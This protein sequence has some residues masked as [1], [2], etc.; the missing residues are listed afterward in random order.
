MIA[1]TNSWRTWAVRGGACAVAA[2]L[3]MAAIPKAYAEDSPDLGDRAEVE[4]KKAEREALE[5]QR[6]SMKIEESD[7]QRESR[8][9]Q[10]AKDKRTK[11]AQ[12]KANQAV[13]AANKRQN[14]KGMALM[15]SAWMTDPLQPEYPRFTAEFAKALQKPEL[16]FRAWS[17]VKT[18]CKLN[19]ASLGPDSP[20]R[21]KYQDML[22]MAEP[23]L[24]FLRTK[25]STGVLQVQVDP[26]SCEI[27]VE[28]AYVG[29]GKGEMELMTGERKVETHCVGYKDMMQF[30]V[31]RQGDPSNA[32]IKCDPIP[33]FG[34]LVLKIDQ[35]EGVT[36]YLDDVPT[37]QRMGDK[38][39]KEGTI[40]GEGTKEKP[41]VL[42]ARRWVLRF[43]KDGYDRW[44]RRIEVRRDQTI[45]I[46]AHLESLTEI[47][48]DKPA[49]GATPGKEGATPGKDSGKD[50]KPAPAKPQK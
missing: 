30:V 27:Y 33:Y 18:L 24:E 41:Y 49:T 9:R 5:K 25:V 40:T 11:S 1:M 7:E 8:E 34:K 22:D 37:A 43:Q 32:K 6:A 38:P 14:D 35:G 20:S 28:G 2:L 21:E 48:A 3:W 50:S 31:V 12:D 4:R 46:D 17:A 26:A 45:L 29:V 19:L 36:T 39:T 10:E 44:H 47:E 13:Q 15:E 42:A 23:R 16:E